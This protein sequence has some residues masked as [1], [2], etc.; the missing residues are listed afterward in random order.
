M[1]RKVFIFA[2]IGACA[3]FIVGTVVP[4]LSAEVQNALAFQHRGL[5]WPITIAGAA[6]G[7]LWGYYVSGLRKD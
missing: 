1:S 7:G 3:V 6:M 5:I 4:F 2:G